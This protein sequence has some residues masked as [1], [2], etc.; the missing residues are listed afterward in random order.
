MKKF[1][2]SKGLVIGLL[3]LALCLTCFGVAK[4]SAEDAAPAKSAAVDAQYDAVND[5]VTAGSN[6]YVYVLKAASGNKLKAG[7][8]ATGQMASNKISIADLGIKSTA[9]D[10]FLYVCD[11]EVE[12]EETV[13][14]NLTIKGNANKV[15]GVID[16][17]QADK[18]DTDVQVGS[19]K[20][21]SA[22]Y[23]DKS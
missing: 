1:N 16:Y 7:Q 21:L 10:V 17:T 18:L 8:A 22:Y 11:K 19:V 2:F 9:K 6:A 23:V 13:S 5:E 14:A 15:V 3:T 12:V 20:V 4:V